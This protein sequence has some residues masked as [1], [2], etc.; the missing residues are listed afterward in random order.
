M[1]FWIIIALGL[2]VIGFAASKL[3]LYFGYRAGKT[4]TQIKDETDVAKSVFGMI[5]AVAIVFT[6]GFSFSEFAL[7][8]RA[9][10]R[11]QLYGALGQLV[12]VDAER[13][14]ISAAALLQLARLGEHT[15]EEIPALLRILTAYINE[16]ARSPVTH[17]DEHTAARPDLQIGMFVLSE[18][19]GENKAHGSLVFL[20]RVDLRYV[21]LRNSS[22]PGVRLQEVDLSNASFQGASLKDATLVDV[23]ME[24]GDFSGVQL[25]GAVLEIVEFQRTDLEKTDFCGAAKLSE[26]VHVTATGRIEI[27]C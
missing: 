7:K 5:G 3:T 12:A 17:H 21:S 10:D 9:E 22:F 2:L 11:Q 16:N 13:P 8:E 25:D 24:D 23:K 18:L 26:V 14:E 1:T 6:L 19:I 4:S 20:N 15:P 27:N